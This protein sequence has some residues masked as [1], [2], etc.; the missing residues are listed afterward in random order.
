MVYRTAVKAGPLERIGHDPDRDRL[1]VDFSDGSVIDYLHVPLFLYQAMFG[2]ADKLTFF[3]EFVQDQHA[4]A[5]VVPADGAA[6]S[7]KLGQVRPARWMARFGRAWPDPIAVATSSVSTPV[8]QRCVYCR[9]SFALG[10]QG[11]LM[12]STRRPGEALLPGARPVHRECRLRAAVGSVAHLEG[13]CPC[14]G[15]AVT[16]DEGEW[17]EQGRATLGWLRRHGHPA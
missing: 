7:P 13:R 8:G 14:G 11:L 5:L 12:P 2:A 16:A 15:G 4:I 1:R 10:D 17:R 6:P 3:V 9:E